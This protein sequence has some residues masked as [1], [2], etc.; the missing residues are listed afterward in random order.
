MAL[1]YL[2]KYQSH[3]KKFEHRLMTITVSSILKKDG[4]WYCADDFGDCPHLCR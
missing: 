3:V 1:L 2:V 4:L